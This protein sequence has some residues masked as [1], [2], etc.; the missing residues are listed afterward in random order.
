MQSKTSSLLWTG[1]GLIWEVALA[2]GLQKGILIDRVPTELVAAG[3]VAPPFVFLCYSLRGLVI[4]VRKVVSLIIFLLIGL[5]AG[6][7]AWWIVS[8]APKPAPT[9]KEN[10]PATHKEVA[11]LGSRIDNFS[12]LFAKSPHVDPDTQLEILKR[13]HDRLSEKKNELTKQEKDSLNE[14]G[15][16]LQS[17]EQARKSYLERVE[18]EKRQEELAQRQKEI[19]DRAAAKVAQERADERKKTLSKPIIPIGDYA[20]D[21]LYEMLSKIAKE[22]SESLYSDFSGAHPSIY[23]SV[24]QKDGMLMDGEHIIRVGSHKEWEFHVVVAL[25]NPHMVMPLKYVGF[26]IQAGNAIMRVGIQYKSMGNYSL[27]N[28]FLGISCRVGDKEL[29][30]ETCSFSEYQKPIHAALTELIHNR[31]NEHPLQ[32][33]K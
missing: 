2:I 7:A 15:L 24:L 6:L 32:P 25:P 23:N 28:A 19:Q 14:Q 1:L 20:I 5:I 21:T 33:P 13:E 31:Y 16:T 26:Q 4:R 3:L 27:E 22:S 17:L 12:D 8:I 11:A 9:S 30:S 10:T 18:T 29:Y